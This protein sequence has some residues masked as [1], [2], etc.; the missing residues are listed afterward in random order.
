MGE[1]SAAE[2]FLLYEVCFYMVEKTE[3]I[4]EYLATIKSEPNQTGHQVFTI[5]LCKGKIQ[6]W[7]LI[8]IRE[9]GNTVSFFSLRGNEKQPRVTKTK[10]LLALNGF[11]EK[12]LYSAGIRHAIGP[13]KFRFAAFLKKLGYEVR[14]GA[15]LS[16]V[17]KKLSP[18]NQGI[19]KVRRFRK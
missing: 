12:E 15:M 7:E 14:K 3:R 16:D 17:S 4:G 8:G 6:F 18:V 2:L 9:Y 10:Q 13:T 11:A 19:G 5:T 1:V